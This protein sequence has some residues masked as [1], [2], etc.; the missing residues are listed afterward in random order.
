[1]TSPIDQ[2]KA[3]MPWWIS[4]IHGFDG[5]EIHPC[6]TEFV[7]DGTPFIEQ[8]EPAEAEFWSVYGHCRE[9]GV[10][11]LEDFAGPEEARAFAGR[12]LAV[13]PHLQAFGL[14]E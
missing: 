5:L 3:L 9:G 7:G 12:L 2:A 11:C 14:L 10:L 1:M 6:R 4:E 8:C 13:W